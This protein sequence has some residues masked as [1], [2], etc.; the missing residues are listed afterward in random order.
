MISH[1]A[2]IAYPSLAEDTL[3]AVLRLC[4]TAGI[5]PITF[6]Q[7]IQ[8]FG[9]ATRALEALPELARRGGKA[10]PFVATSHE[11]A[12]KEIEATQAF[13]AR[14]VVYGSPEYPK[15]LLHIPDAPPVISIIGNSQLWQDTPL[16]AMVGARNASANGCQFAQKLARELGQRGVVVV[17]GLARGIDSFAHRGALAHGTIGVIA[18]GI[19]TIYPPENTSLFEQMREQGAI[20]SEQPFGGLPYAGSFPGRNRIIAGMSLGT[21]VVEASP[22]SGSLITAR[23]ALEYGREVLAIPGSPLDP[24]A[25]GGNQLIKQ[26]AAM[27]ETVDDIM[28]AITQTPHFS[29]TPRTTYASEHAREASINN[30]E[31]QTLVLE[32]L[33]ATAVLVDELIEQCQTPA[34]DVLTVLLELELAGRLRR[35]AGNKVYLVSN[36]EE[37][38]A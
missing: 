16:V 4:R 1:T 26:G 34:G 33:G 22:K 28:Q 12:L 18:G 2:P 3:P 38:V 25:R 9:N 5:G 10:K 32:K 15:G 29:E 7:L 30:E 24:R 27:I 13:G 35:S 36:L 23:F 17:S 14:L 11:D 31:L 8:R 21:L 19:D 37:E 6:F 20:I